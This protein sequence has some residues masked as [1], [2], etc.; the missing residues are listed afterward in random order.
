M[1]KSRGIEQTFKILKFLAKNKNVSQYDLPQKIGCSYRTL[2]RHLKELKREGLAHIVKT[3]VSSKGGLEK[4]IWEITVQGL[5]AVL[6]YAEEISGEE[7]EEIAETQKDKL[8]L[9][10]KWDYFAKKGLRESLIEGIRLAS[11]EIAEAIYVKRF[12]W[13]EKTDLD[14]N[15]LMAIALGLIFLEDPQELPKE[16]GFFKDF[17]KACKQDPELRQ[18]VEGFLN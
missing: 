17:W 2:L 1:K 15:D 13:G 8:L 5:I 4:N 18:F 12:I 6:V 3:E 10:K 9:F 11:E 7:L 14:E 16:Y